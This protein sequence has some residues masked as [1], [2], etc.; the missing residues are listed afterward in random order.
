M[1]DVGASTSPTSRTRCRSASRRRRWAQLGAA[2][3]A[4]RPPIGDVRAPTAA[5][6][7][8]AFAADERRAADGP[9]GEGAARSASSISSSRRWRNAATATSPARAL[10]ELANRASRQRPKEIAPRRRATS[11]RQL[12]RRRT[13]AWPAG[14]RRARADATSSVG[15]PP[16]R[17]SLGDMTP[18]KLH[19]MQ[20]R[21][22]ASVE[23]ALADDD[24][25]DDVMTARRSAVGD[26]RR[27]ARG[28]IPARSATA[29]WP[30]GA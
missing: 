22:Q 28:S 25:D 2:R 19:Q 30:R 16:L 12:D 9:T 13:C 20:M 17:D 18:E 3:F 7:A 4:G 11:E 8:A 21:H 1:S 10:A 14:A 24:D 26:G 23:D 5:R 29:R 6:R 15:L 27:E